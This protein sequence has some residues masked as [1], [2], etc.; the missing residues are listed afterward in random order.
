MKSKKAMHG[1]CYNSIFKSCLKLRKKD[2]SEDAIQ[3]R[4][5]VHVDEHRKM[6][7]YDVVFRGQE[8]RNDEDHLRAKFAHFRRGALMSLTTVMIERGGGVSSNL[9]KV[10]AT[11]IDAPHEI[12]SQQN[13]QHSSASCG[14]PTKH[15]L[16]CDVGQLIQSIES[17]LDK[18]RP[19]NGKLKKMS[20]P[21]EAGSEEKRYF[22][23][24]K[25]ALGLALRQKTE[26]NCIDLGTLM[27]S[28]AKDQQIPAAKN[29]LARLQSFRKRTYDYAQMFRDC[30][31]LCREHWAKDETSNASTCTDIVALLRTVPM[32]D[33][34]LQWQKERWKVPIVVLG[35]PDRVTAPLPELLWRS[36]GPESQCFSQCQQLFLSELSLQDS[37]DLCAGKLLERAFLWACAVNAGQDLADELFQKSI[38]EVKG[39]MIFE[40]RQQGG[41]VV[42]WEASNSLQSDILYYADEGRG[43]QSHPWTD[44]WICRKLENQEGTCSVLLM[45][46]YGGTNSQ[47]AGTKLKRL[48]KMCKHLCE[49]D[50]RKWQYSGLVLAPNLKENDCTRPFPNFS[51]VQIWQ[52]K[53]RKLLGGMVQLLCWLDPDASGST[54]LQDAGW[55][56]GNPLVFS[57]SVV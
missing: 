21:C 28:I 52:D 7:D 54:S 49:K 46:I 37:T 24:F 19:L 53:A 29:F 35:N 6:L 55:L 51:S 23:A 47:T 5:L 11:Y 1:Q 48:S 25:V 8:R 31:E 13:S 42:K 32:E 20:L 14:I 30:V 43:K 44:M 57:C 41:A 10:I 18:E 12:V 33:F 38:K 3:G 50:P 16:Y 36:P 17:F 4:L 34:T 27:L 40:P 9:V 56:P 39:S 22:A 2:D 45:E 26:G 15:F